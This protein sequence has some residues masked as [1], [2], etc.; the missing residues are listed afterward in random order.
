M[1]QKVP[2]DTGLGMVDEIKQP[3]ND[4]YNNSAQRVLFLVKH[5]MKV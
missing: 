5:A 2:K 4:C 1:T 3:V